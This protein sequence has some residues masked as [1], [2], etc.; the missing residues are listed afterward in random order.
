MVNHE[1]ESE[2]LRI[3][4]FLVEHPSLDGVSRN[5]VAARWVED[6]LEK[7]PCERAEMRLVEIMGIDET[8]SREAMHGACVAEVCAE[9]LVATAEAHAATATGD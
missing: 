7:P 1:N 5:G 2:L 3:G 4:E 8:Q 9:E 6:E